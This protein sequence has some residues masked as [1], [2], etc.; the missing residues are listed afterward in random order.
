MSW[1]S[2]LLE[3]FTELVAN[4]VELIAANL[5][6]D[7]LLVQQQSMLVNGFDTVDDLVHG[8]EFRDVFVAWLLWIW[9]NWSVFDWNLACKVADVAEADKFWT[10]D[11]SEKDKLEDISH[12]SNH[13]HKS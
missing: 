12:L 5:E 8:D 11:R 4:D 3:K 9:S 13:T 2:E 10:F 7:T 1:L 6:T